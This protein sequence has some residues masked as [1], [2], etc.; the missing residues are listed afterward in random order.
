MLVS[1]RAAAGPSSHLK[2]IAARVM[3]CLAIPFFDALLPT[4]VLI[5]VSNVHESLR[6]EQRSSCKTLTT[7]QRGAP[8]APVVDLTFA[9]L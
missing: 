7:P 5:V 2:S 6:T 4:M 9:A 3:E 8:T 1:V